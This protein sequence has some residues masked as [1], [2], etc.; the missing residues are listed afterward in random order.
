MTAPS[1]RFAEHGDDGV[2]L[3]E[4]V[5]SSALTLLV[6]A[7]VAAFYVNISAATLAARNLRVAT[8]TAADAIDELGRVIR[9]SADNAVVG[10]GTADPAVAYATPQAVTLLSYIDTSSTT[11]QPSR[12]VFSVNAGKLI[13]SRTASTSSSGI[14]LFTGATTT[15][16]LGGPFDSTVPLFAYFDENGNELVPASS[17]LTLA[18]RQAVSS[19]KL[20]V[21]IS[22]RGR[23]GSAPV[24]L[25]SSVG[26]IN[27]GLSGTGN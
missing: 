25:T 14:W 3:I 1:R 27:L 15:R 23:T 21:V 7:A 10:G 9:V 6:L 19:I 4:L 11:P 24:E 26:M 22:N 13:E 2:T 17:G 18:Q 20:R 8:G 12:V 16:S 5:V